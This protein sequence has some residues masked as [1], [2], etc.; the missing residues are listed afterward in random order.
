MCAQTSTICQQIGP[1]NNKCQPQ[2]VYQCSINDI[3]GDTTL[4]KGEEGL[5]WKKCGK[6][7]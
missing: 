5:C 4:H 7:V 2:D 6:Y 1:K 3:E